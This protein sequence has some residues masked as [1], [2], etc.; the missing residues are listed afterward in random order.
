M[1]NDCPCHDELEIVTVHWGDGVLRTDIDCDADVDPGDA[2][3]DLLHVAQLA[4]P[5]IG[6]CPEVGA[7][8]QGLTDFVWGDV[9]C[10]DEVT[11]TDVLAILLVT[12]GNFTIQPYDCPWA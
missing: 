5:S 7:Q 4:A 6:A 9:D 1:S 10:D 8:P 11:T 12:S 2:I 3:R